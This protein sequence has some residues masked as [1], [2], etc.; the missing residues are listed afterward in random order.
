M[1]RATNEL[2]LA[3]FGEHAGHWPFGNRFAFR[4]CNR[5]AARGAL[6]QFCET[7]TFGPRGFLARE[8]GNR[9][10][11]GQLLSRRLSGVVRIKDCLGGYLRRLVDTSVSRHVKG[12]L[13]AGTRRVAQWGGRSRGQSG[14]VEQAVS[15]DGCWR[16]LVLRH[17]IAND[18]DQPEPVF[19]LN[20][21]GSAND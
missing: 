9:P 10:P 17:A 8:R 18:S 15:N 12:V 7:G 21:R 4:T 19:R 14:R 11:K 3:K 1:K 16:M 6:H 5:F 13:H 20:G 2:H